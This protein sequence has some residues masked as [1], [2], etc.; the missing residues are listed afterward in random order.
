MH[1]EQE[2]VSPELPS[3]QRSGSW[4]VVSTIRTT[5]ALARLFT[6]HYLSMGAD[7]IFFFHDDPSEA[8]DLADARVRA[9]VCD[10]AW[11]RGS[12]PQ[13]LE[14]RQQ[15]NASA[16]RKWCRSTWLLHCDIDEL[17]WAAKPVRRILKELPPDVGGM[18]VRPAEAVYAHP[19][20]PDGVFSTPFFK[21]FETE[22]GKTGGLPG[23]SRK[24]FGD[25]WH[26][27]KR[28]FWAHIGGKSFIRREVPLKHMPLHKI[29]RE[30][31][32]GFSMHHVAQGM[33][34]RHYDILSFHQW[35]D[36]HMR[37]INNEVQVP[38]AGR[39]REL[40]QE[41]IA[42]AARQ[43][44]GEALYRLYLRMAVM[45]PETLAEC[46]A[47]GYVRTIRPERHLLDYKDVPV[48]TPAAQAKT[49][50]PEAE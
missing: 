34:L 25:I 26:A 47:H 48:R 18:I 49:A 11:W 4:S 20:T 38:L 17:L 8:F 21:F 45:Q 24:A 3:L 33:I 46:V 19:P 35:R 5:P 7:E 44:D 10:D 43:A 15:S 23:V 29:R 6:D 41:L 31:M 37:R 22:A 9:T 14:D 42:E 1:S 16:A 50:F 27:S 39:L 13:G 28:G 32:G 2:E 36:K 30:R 12:R 40:Q